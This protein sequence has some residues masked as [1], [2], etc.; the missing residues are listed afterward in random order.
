MGRQNVR[1]KRINIDESTD[2]EKT[3]EK[4][5]GDRFLGPKINHGKKTFSYPLLFRGFSRGAAGEGN[6]SCR[7]LTIPAQAAM[8]QTGYCVSNCG[9]GCLATSQTGRWLG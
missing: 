3:F 8:L 7:R 5:R 2:G 4:K 1:D 9:L 6:G